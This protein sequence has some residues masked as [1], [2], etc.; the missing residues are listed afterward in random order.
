MTTLRLLPLL[1]IAAIPLSHAGEAVDPRL[2]PGST[3]YVDFPDLPPTWNNQQK[4]RLGIFLPDDYTPDR[5]YPLMVW[6]GSGGG[7]DNPGSA[8]NMVGRKGY[9]CA[10]V[11]YENS[12]GWK[13][14]WAYYN[15]M[16]RELDRV[17]PNIHPEY[18]VC[19]GFSSG[20]AA[21]TYSMGTSKEF[22]E[23]FYAFVPG[24]AGWAMGDLSPLKG[25]PMLAFMG[26]QDSRLSGYVSLVE[27]AEAAGMDVKFLKF[28]GGHDMPNQHFQ[29]IRDWL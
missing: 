22:V 28:P 4:A 25:R 8:V 20:G 9:I 16:L 29:E 12:K 15:T 21:I 14:P 10:G 1:L 18:R 3:I 26:D 24:G 17:V 11:P 6:F 5:T 27:M 23:Y 2:Q 13:T 7:G 19:S